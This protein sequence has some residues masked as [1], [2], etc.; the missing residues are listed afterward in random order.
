MDVN[1]DSG[2]SIEKKLTYEQKV[3]RL[4]GDYKRKYD[5]VRIYASICRIPTSVFQKRMEEYLDKLYEVQISYGD[6]SSVIGDD[7]EEF[8]KGL[9]SEHSFL[10]D[11][12]R[13]IFKTVAKICIFVLFAFLL[14][15]FFDDYANDV[16][17]VGGCLFIPLASAVVFSFLI[18]FV[19]KKVY[20]K[21]NNVSP[22]V[23]LIIDKGVNSI[24][25]IIV[26]F[27]MDSYIEKL[28]NGLV[29]SKETVDNLLGTLDFLVLIIVSI[30]YFIKGPNDNIFNRFNKRLDM[31][32]QR[33]NRKK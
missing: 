17:E 14:F 22:I 33:D 11:K 16:D 4:F 28:C 27:C 12:A 29:N 19:L 18:W 10:K 3:N 24:L 2:V 31:D 30:I 23:F 15:G 9:F 6:A 13:S 1:G 5:R 21:V 26:F 25:I 20:V 8:C 7:I 32:K